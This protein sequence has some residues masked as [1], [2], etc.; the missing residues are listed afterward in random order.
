MR[1]IFNTVDDASNA[2]SEIIAA[3]II[4]A[5]MELMDQGILAAVEE[6]FQF[7]FPP[8]AGAV[9]VIEVDGPAAG[10]DEQQEQIVEF[11]RRCGAREVLQA[12]SAPSERELLWKCRKMAVGA[13]GRLSPSYT[14]QDGVVPRTRLPHILRRIAEIGQKHQHAHRQRGPRRRRQRP[15]DPAVR[16]AR[17]RTRS[18]GRVAAGREILGGVHRLR[19]QHHGRARHRRREDRPDGRLF[20]PADLEAMRRVRAAFDPAG[21]LSPGKLLPPLAAPAG[22]GV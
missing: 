13:V 11:C 12:A 1:A 10:L 3:G 15:S 9:L 5:A 20:A 16:R 2:V 6:A 18:S 4:P 22:A 17:P 21:R 8:D 19:R 7:G 14:I